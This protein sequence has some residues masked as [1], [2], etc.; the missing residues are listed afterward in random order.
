MSY[1]IISKFVDESNNFHLH[2]LHDKKTFT[3]HSIFFFHK[4]L[5]LIGEEIQDFCN[6]H[7]F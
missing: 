5:N 6:I 1:L 3:R 4:N 2:I 7:Y